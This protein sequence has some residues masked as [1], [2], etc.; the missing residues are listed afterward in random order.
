MAGEPRILAVSVLF[1]SLAALA[2]TFQGCVFFFSLL[3]QSLRQR[4]LTAQ[5]TQQY[6]VTITR[7]RR[8]RRRIIN[9]RGRMW[10]SSERNL[11]RLQMQHELDP[12]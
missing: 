5:T 10:R 9:R 1:L 4:Q 6:N 12:G 3:M 11:V 2:A 8:I 7:L